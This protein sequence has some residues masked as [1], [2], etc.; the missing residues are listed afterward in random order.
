M[1]PLLPA[2]VGAFTFLPR[3]LGIMGNKPSADSPFAATPVAIVQQ[4]NPLLKNISTFCD[5]W[6]KR[7]R[8]LSSPWPRQGSFDP[9]LICTIRV[10]VETHKAKDRTPERTNKRSEELQVLELFFEEGQKLV[11]SR[12]LKQDKM[13]AATLEATMATTTLQEKINAPFSHLPEILS[14]ALKAPLIPVPPP[15]KPQDSTQGTQYTSPYPLLPLLE[16]GGPYKITSGDGETELEQGEADLLLRLTP[17]VQRKGGRA[18]GSDT[19]SGSL[20]KASSG[21]KSRGSVS[22]SRSSPSHGGASRSPE[23]SSAQE[24]EIPSCYDQRVSDLLVAAERKGRES[25]GA[26]SSSCYDQRTSDVLAAAEREGRGARS[27]QKK[28]LIPSSSSSSGSGSGDDSG[29]DLDTRTVCQARVPGLCDR[30]ESVR[31]QKYDLQM[32]KIFPNARERSPSELEEVDSR[33]TTLN[34]EERRL[35]SDLDTVTLTLDKPPRKTVK[36]KAQETQ[37]S[38]YNL[39]PRTH[40]P[41]LAINLPNR[42]V[43]PAAAAA[44]ASPILGPDPTISASPPPSRDNSP[45]PH[46]SRQETPISRRSLG[47]GEEG[48]EGATAAAKIC[49]VKVRRGVF[50]YDAWTNVDVSDVVSKLPPIQEGASPWISKFEQIMIGTQLAMG[51]I[52]R[53]LSTL[54]GPAAMN[55]IFRKARLDKYIDTGAYDGD[56]FATHKGPLWRALRDVYVTNVHPDSIILDPLGETENARAY[57]ERGYQTWMNA[58]G[59]NPA[60]NVLEQA[61]VR[62]LIE[63]GLPTPVRTK[64]AE[65]VGLSSMSKQIYS[66][67]ISHQV[68][69]YRKRLE[70]QRESDRL[71][72]R[73]LTQIKIAAKQAATQQMTQGPAQAGPAS[74]PAPAQQWG[75]APAPAPAQQWGGWQ[76]G[77]RGIRRGGGVSQRP[78]GVC[79]NCNQQGHLYYTC[80]LPL[81]PSLARYLP[82]PAGAPPV[83][84]NPPP[85]Q[86]NPPQAAPLTQQLPRMVNPYRGPPPGG[87]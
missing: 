7:W 1:L 36:R 23:R 54:I 85:F 59:S 19:V 11:R 9:A 79:W 47:L 3:L 70:S 83:Q 38:D 68:T 34:I 63:K 81:I 82:V 42:R 14:S 21:S 20:L 28:V 10:L 35:R 50:D 71:D 2:V 76:A 52:R 74:A 37:R 56:F 77:R 16:S 13:L 5:R 62:T 78:S 8:Y 86:V 22:F 69:F 75:S 25:R 72:M 73:K 67:H 64:L 49:P 60:D 39:R 57:V 87:L 55:D 80:P 24:D 84:A 31:R 53:L 12:K 33:L 44:T 58:T 40:T 48:E 17:A 4:N 41:T 46:P 51:D 15:Y 29:P 6:A 45:P 27:K 61:I 18:S 26:V 66:D 32:Q 43:S 30:L 65:V